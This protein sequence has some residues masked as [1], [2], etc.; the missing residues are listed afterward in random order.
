MHATDETNGLMFLLV[1]A[2]REETEAIIRE[3]G[4][5]FSFA[6]IRFSSILLCEQLILPLQLFDAYILHSYSM[7]FDESSTLFTA[8]E[9]EVHR[10]FKVVH[11][12]I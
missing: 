1:H 8:R 4:D 9:E 3:G 7:F 11:P 5:F 10:L 12:F 6:N 2:C